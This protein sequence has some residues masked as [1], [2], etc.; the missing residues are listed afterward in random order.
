MKCETYVLQNRS[1]LQSFIDC[2][3]HNNVKNYLEIGCKFGGSLWLIGNSLPSG[4]KIVAVDLPRGDL[5]FKEN[6]GHLREC[7]T[8]LRKRGYQTSLILGDSTD[9][10]VVEQVYELGPYDAVFIDA[11]H[12]LPYINK[13]WSNYGKI[14]KIV[15]FHDIA[16]LRED[17]MDVGKKPIDV[18][19][20]WNKIKADHRHI[21]F[22][23]EPVRGAKGHR[24]CDNGIGV[25][26]PN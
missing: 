14:G 25:L 15:A 19:Q 4:S 2:L 21:E 20:F 7:I 1:E 6:E 24:K 9:K 23:Y 16:F 10:D 17:G 11:N 22:R 5:S 18:P 26:W 12:T 13:D 8:E 3:K